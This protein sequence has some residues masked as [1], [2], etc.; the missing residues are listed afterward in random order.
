MEHK[1]HPALNGGLPVIEP[2]AAGLDLGSV[3]IWACVPADRAAV[4]VRAFGTCTPD[5]VELTEWLVQCGVTSVAM[6][7]TGMYWVPVFEVLEARGLQVWVINPHQLKQVPG[8][9]SDVK[10]CQWIQRLHTFGLLSN[11]FQP[12]AAMRAL[13]SYLRQRAMLLE[14]RAAHVQHMQKALQQMNVQVGQAVKDITGQTGLAIIRDIVAG[15]RDPERLAAHRHPRCTK[16]PAE[17]VKALTGSYREEHVFALK[18]ALVLY[19]AYTAQVQECDRAIEQQWRALPPQTDDDLPPPKARVKP[20]THSKNGPAYDARDLLYKATGVDLCAIPG[21][22]A[23]TVQVILAEIGG[24]VSAWP[25]AKHFC[26]WLALAPQHAIS[27]GKVLHKGVPKTGNRAGQAFRLAAQTLLRSPDK[28]LG[29]FCRRARAKWGP[30]RAIIATAHKLARIFYTMLKTR[31]Q[32]DEQRALADDERQR[33]RKLKYLE[34]EAAK[35]GCALTPFPVNVP[36]I[37]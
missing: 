31:I 32:F 13:R 26:A 29:A 15:E 20:E 14:H 7:A 9:K 25:T 34:R 37:S 18:Q 22:G 35:Y 2:N 23:T 4:A 3:E 30:E 27:G 21:L 6:E 17:M 33:Q 36:V 19:D 12:E 1:S 11:S 24:S 16:T 8:R 10:D 5:L 28:P